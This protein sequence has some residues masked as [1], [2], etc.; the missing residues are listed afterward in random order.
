MKKIKKLFVGRL[1]KLYQEKRRLPN[2]YTVSLEVIRHP[3]A[4]LVVPFLGPDKII[5]IRQFR[6][7][8]DSYIWELPA[9]TLDKDEKL[10]TA[11][12]RELAEEIGY[13]AKVLK[14]AGY[15]YPAPGYTT[16]KIHIYEARLLK[17]V[18]T[19]NEPDEVITPRVFN[20]KGIV[21]LLKQGKIVDAK[22]ICA[23]KLV[24]II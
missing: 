5:M 17:K 10:S 2:G 14:K 22:T 15:I 12:K 20:K 9:G 7:V 21:K 3:G 4:I 8:I 1:L 23:L 13:A 18:E 6:P 24:G 11:V 16:E 19:K